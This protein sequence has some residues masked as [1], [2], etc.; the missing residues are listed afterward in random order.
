MQE[1]KKKQE[2]EIEEKKKKYWEEQQR[3]YRETRGKP[4]DHGV[5]FPEFEDTEWIDKQLNVTN[6]NMTELEKDSFNEEDMQKWK[7]DIARQLQQEKQESEPSVI[8]KL[9][10][11]IDKSLIEKTRLFKPDPYK[12]N[13]SPFTYKFYNPKPTSAYS[14]SDIRSFGKNLWDQ[15]DEDDERGKCS[16]GVDFSKYSNSQN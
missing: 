1:A 7:E 2:D 12:K 6:V 3:I 14:S 5:H 13:R 8:E 9:N 15:V 4:I 16:T 11:K 10:E